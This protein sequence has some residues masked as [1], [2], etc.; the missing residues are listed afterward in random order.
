MLDQWNRLCISFLSIHPDSQ[1]HLTAI[2]NYYLHSSI[3]ASYSFSF[4][5]N[6]LTTSSSVSYKCLVNQNDLFHKEKFKEW[7]DFC[8]CDPSAFPPILE[9]LYIVVGVGLLAMQRQSWQL[10]NLWQV[11]DVN[12]YIVKLHC[13][14]LFPWKSTC[15]TVCL[16]TLVHTYIENYNTY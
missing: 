7:V 16:C 4:S 14:V 6:H 9:R 8:L 2:F 10:A 12:I 15:L 1:S 5:T 3:L 11:L 13:L